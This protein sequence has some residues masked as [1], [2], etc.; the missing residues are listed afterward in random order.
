[1]S[2][3]SSRASPAACMSSERRWRTYP[4]PMIIVRMPARRFSDLSI[5][6]QH[7]NGLLTTANR[8]PSNGGYAIDELPFASE[9]RSGPALRGLESPPARLT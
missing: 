2:P 5:H 4:S 3:A 8:F 1:M 6:V 9:S 7:Q